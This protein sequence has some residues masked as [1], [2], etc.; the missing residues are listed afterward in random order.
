MP[1]IDIKESP[2]AC[3]KSDVAHILLVCNPSLSLPI[4]IYY[5]I[6]LVGVTLGD[7]FVNSLKAD[8]E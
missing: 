8:G 1:G 7:S 6:S 3:F 5:H 4:V 2:V